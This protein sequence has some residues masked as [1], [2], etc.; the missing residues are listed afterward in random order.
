MV[1][2]SSR[3]ITVAF[4]C[5]CA[6]R[7]RRPDQQAASINLSIFVQFHASRTRRTLNL[8]DFLCDKKP[9]I[10]QRSP[11]RPHFYGWFCVFSMALLDLD[12]LG[13]S[14]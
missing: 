11:R 12:G 14:K 6:L 3:L 5:A 10:S 13:D 1:P 8:F 7:D 9:F 2:R 4:D